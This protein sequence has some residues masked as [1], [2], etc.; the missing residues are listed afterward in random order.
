MSRV[1][2]YVSQSKELVFIDASS[3]FEE[4]NNPLFLVLTSSAAGG[5]PLGIV[6]TSSESAKV[7]HQGM[8][9]LVNYFLKVR[10][11]VQMK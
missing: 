11:I 2:K 5:L 1:H 8:T 4:F 10:F 9:M 6:M 7:V 3:S